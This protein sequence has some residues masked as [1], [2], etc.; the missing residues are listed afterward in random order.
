MFGFDLIRHLSIDFT[1]G[2]TRAH[3]VLFATDY[4]ELY[5]QTIWFCICEN[6]NKIKIKKYLNFPANVHVIVT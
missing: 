1:C 6:K 2:F 4:F 5:E 3:V